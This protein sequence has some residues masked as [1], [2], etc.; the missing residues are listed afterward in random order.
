MLKTAGW[1]SIFMFLVVLMMAFT[2]RYVAEETGLPPADMRMV[3][4]NISGIC[5]VAGLICCA[6]AYLVGAFEGES[7]VRLPRRLSP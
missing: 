2:A 6:I 4:E 7:K 3:L 1:I 5:S